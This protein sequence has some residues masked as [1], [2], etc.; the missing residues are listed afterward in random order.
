MPFNSARDAAIGRC[1]AEASDAVSLDPAL[2]EAHVALGQSYLYISHESD[3]RAIPEFQ[4][5]AKLNPRN[6]DAYT[7]LATIASFWLRFEEALP[8]AKR[9]YEL[10]PVNVQF[11]FTLGNSYASVNQLPEAETIFRRLISLEPSNKVYFQSQLAKVLAAEGKNE[12]ARRLFESSSDASEW[13]RLWIEA[14]LGPVAGR[15]SEATAALKRL[16]H[17]DPKDV[18]PIAIADIYAFHGDLNQ[19]FEWMERQ[20]QV[21]PLRLVVELRWDP[22]LVKTHGDPRF[23]LLRRKLELPDMVVSDVAEH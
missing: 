6:P 21:S 17:A 16:E 19:A 4:L 13:Y 11:L 10:D 3:K 1:R 22:L 14:L 5:A 9:A 2:D 7:E 18:A 20:R 15:S 8:L 23:Q 12:E